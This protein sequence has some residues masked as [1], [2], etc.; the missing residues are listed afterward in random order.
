MVLRDTLILVSAG[1]LIGIPGALVVTRFASSLL[2]GLKPT[3]PLT[4]VTATLVLLLV[5]MLAG[6]MP[7]W[8]ASRLD[9]ASALRHE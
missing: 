3:D 4:M 8:Q 5:A 9:P 1:I 6:Y 7:A 2:F